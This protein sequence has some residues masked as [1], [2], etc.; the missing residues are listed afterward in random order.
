VSS[1]ASICWY[2]EWAAT[3]SSI[4]STIEEEAVN[5]KFHARFCSVLLT[6]TFC[7]IGNA[8]AQTS[9][10]KQIDLVSDVPDLA[11]NFD[12][13]LATPWGIALSADQPFRVANNG[14]GSFAS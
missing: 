7:A 6:I 9:S 1:S 2:Q 8:S 3:N 4:N 13:R 5:R 14:N 10:Y 12:P 11:A